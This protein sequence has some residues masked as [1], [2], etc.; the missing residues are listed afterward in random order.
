MRAP[1]SAIAM[2]TTTQVS[3]IAMI[4]VLSRPI[5]RVPPSVKSGGAVEIGG[6]PSFDDAELFANVF[7]V[8][9]RKEA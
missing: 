9:N 7:K 8:D 5:V 3:S 1:T 2:P 4:V 6:L